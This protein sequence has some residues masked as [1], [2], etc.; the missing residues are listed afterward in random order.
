MGQDTLN[1]FEIWFTIHWV[2]YI[3][4]S[5]FSIALFLEI[6][7]NKIQPRFSNIPDKAL[8]FI[9]SEFAVITLFTVQHCFL[10]LYPCFKAAAVRD[11]GSWKAHKKDQRSSTWR[12]PSYPWEKTALYPVPRQQEVRVSYQLLLCSTTIRVQRC[13]H[14]DIHRSLGCATEI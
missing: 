5:F 3:V 13:L 6:L 8:E 2:S 9:D 7:E 11:C 1:L 14:I 4:T 10:F 12:T